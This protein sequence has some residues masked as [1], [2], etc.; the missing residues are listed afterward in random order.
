MK[1]IS[2][3]CQVVGVAVDD[4]STTIRLQQGDDALANIMTPAVP[5]LPLMAPYSLTIEFPGD[6]VLYKDSDEAGRVTVLAR[7]DGIE[8]VKGGPEGDGP[9]RA[10]LNAA[11]EN[12]HAAQV[13]LDPA[14]GKGIAWDTPVAFLIRPA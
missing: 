8:R 3:P 5:S 10:L 14:Q 9:D 6:N 1:S 7:V 2:I 12:G 11:N 13:L 4:G